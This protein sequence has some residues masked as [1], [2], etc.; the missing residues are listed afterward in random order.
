M[1]YPTRMSGFGKISSI[2]LLGLCYLIDARSLHTK[3]VTHWLYTKTDIM[4]NYHSLEFYSEVGNK[5]RKLWDVVGFSF[6]FESVFRFRW[7]IFP[8]FMQYYSI[9]GKK[10][11][12]SGLNFL[13]LYSKKFLIIYYVN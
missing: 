11:P 10:N 4:N 5:M 2:F 12:S 7:Y 9:R 1:M 3:Q 8:I 6:L 13:K